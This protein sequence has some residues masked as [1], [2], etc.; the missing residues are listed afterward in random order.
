MSACYLGCIYIEVSEEKHF[1]PSLATEWHFHEIERAE[2]QQARSELG[3]APGSRAG[4]LRKH[5]Y[6]WQQT[7]QVAPQGFCGTGV[8]GDVCVGMQAKH[9]R[10][11]D[12]RQAFYCCHV[13]VVVPKDRNPAWHLC[14]KDLMKSC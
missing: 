11:L 14:V 6:G 9:L 7:Y 3:L 4:T 5:S 13:T 1:T 2:L 10:G 8:V 12:Q